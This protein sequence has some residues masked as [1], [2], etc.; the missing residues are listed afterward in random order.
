VVAALHVA[1]AGI[2]PS[3]WAGSVLAASS[4]PAGFSDPTAPLAASALEGLGVLAYAALVYLV[5]RLAARWA[6]RADDAA[7]VPAS[8]SVARSGAT[9]SPSRDSS[10]TKGPGA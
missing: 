5:L 4:G 8:A 2:G 10:S 6:D 9:P 1:A 7:V 3:T